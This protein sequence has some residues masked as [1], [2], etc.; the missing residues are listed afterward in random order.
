MTDVAFCMANSSLKLF[1]PGGADSFFEVV[2]I[3]KGVEVKMAVLGPWKMWPS[4]F[5]EANLSKFNSMMR[6]SI[7]KYRYEYSKHLRF[8]VELQWLEHLWDYENLL[9]PGVVRPVEGLL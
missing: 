7:M 3:E 4:T 9:E 2:P 6:M 1:A 5:S 8:T